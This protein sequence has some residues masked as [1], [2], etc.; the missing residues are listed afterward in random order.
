MGRK[1]G[2][3]ARL[4]EGQ[5]GPDLT[6]CGQGRGLPA[7]QVSSWS[8]K[9]FGQN[10]PTLQT[11]RT[12]QDRQRSDSIGR[13]I[14]QTVAQKITLHS[15]QTARNFQGAKFTLR[16]SVAFSYIGSVTAQ[17]WVSA[18][19]CG[20]GQGRELRSF[21]SSFAPPIFCRAAMTLGIGPH[22]SCMWLLSV[23]R[24]LW[25]RHLLAVSSRNDMHPPMPFRLY[26]W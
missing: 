17:Q 19:R 3:C 2:G 21:R 20:M 18:K 4:W 13:T 10:T 7:C 23:V 15:L 11:D 12:G 24:C 6:Q 26:R 25:H 9:P 8:V 1:L 14:L 16:P 5:L 22:S